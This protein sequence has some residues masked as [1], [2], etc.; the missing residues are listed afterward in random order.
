[1]LGAIPTQSSYAILTYCIY[2]DTWH[3]A[4][5]PKPICIQLVASGLS[6]CKEKTFLAIH[7]FQATNLRFCNLFEFYLFAHFGVFAY[8]Y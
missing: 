5:V 1:M 4:T 6:V 7:I 8:K 2:V 3:K